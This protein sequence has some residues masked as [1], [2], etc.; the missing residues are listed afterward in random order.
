MILPGSWTA[1]G[2][3]HPASAA[4]RARSRPVTA[5]VRISS[6]PPACPTAAVADVS[7]RTRGYK[8]VIFTLKVLL[9]SESVDV[10][11][12]HSPKSGALSTS[13]TPAS[14]P[15]ARKP[16]VSCGLPLSPV[17]YTHL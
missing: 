17:S 7:T 5:T 12:P 11:N 8:P 13:P 2:L 9:D 6:T 14:H 1:N 3:R 10:R 4:D 15:R 16:E